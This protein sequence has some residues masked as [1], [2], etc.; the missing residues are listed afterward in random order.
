MLKSSKENFLSAGTEG[1]VQ[2]RDYINFKDAQ[3]LKVYG[4]KSQT[5]KYIS[6]SSTKGIAYVS[7]TDGSFYVWKYLQCDIKGNDQI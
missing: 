6:P 3:T 7:G 1:T 5:I 2:I 4:W